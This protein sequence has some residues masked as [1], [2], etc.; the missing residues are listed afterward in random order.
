MADKGFET[1]SDGTIQNFADMIKQRSQEVPGRRPNNYYLALN[2]TE[3]PVDHDTR[4]GLKNKASREQE[5][6]L[7]G[8]DGIQR[9]TTWTDAPAPVNEP[10]PYESLR[11]GFAKGK[12]YEF[13]ESSDKTTYVSQIDISQLPSKVRDR[14]AKIIQSKRQDKPQDTNSI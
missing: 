3:Y 8:S 11:Y 10:D 13:R 2:V 7:I 5:V 6:L 12:F 9:K 14:F 1:M 4:V